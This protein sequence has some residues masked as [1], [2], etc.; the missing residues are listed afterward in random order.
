MV[1]E[2]QTAL[3][4][5]A[6]AGNLSLNADRTIQKASNLQQLDLIPFLSKH[7]RLMRHSTFSSESFD[8]GICLETKKGARCTRLRKCGHVFCVECLYSYFELNIREG[9]VRNVGCADAECVKRN[10]KLGKDQH[11]S[12]E[13]E[14]IEE[15]VGAE[16]KDRYV[17]LLEKQ[18]VESGMFSQ[19]IAPQSANNLC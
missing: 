9:M 2:L 7:D 10:Q 5:W 13:A 3:V 17:W 15:I 8:C 4:D 1:D 6:S 14:E 19:I 18:R 11:G 12:I 16:L